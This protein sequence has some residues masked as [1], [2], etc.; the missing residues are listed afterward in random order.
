M[1]GRGKWGRKRDEDD[2]EQE[3]GGMNGREEDNEREER[4]GDDNE[5][6]ESLGGRHVREKRGLAE[7]QTG[8]VSDCLTNWLVV[9]IWSVLKSKV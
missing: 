6:W 7:Q 8:W 3:K 2:K 4:D 9:E 1:N 5:G